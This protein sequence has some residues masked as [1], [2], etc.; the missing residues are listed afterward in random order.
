MLFAI[1]MV[2]RKLF[3]EKFKSEKN[4]KKNEQTPACKISQQKS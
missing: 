3:F 4:Q 2:F 1:L